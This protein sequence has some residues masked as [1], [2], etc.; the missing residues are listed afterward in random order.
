[1][2]TEKKPFL[3][4]EQ[5]E[6]MSGDA[7]AAQAVSSYEF[8]KTVG[9][10]RGLSSGRNIYERELSRREARYREVMQAACDAI[11][12]ATD[13][14][15]TYEDAEWKDGER[16]LILLKSMGIEPTNTK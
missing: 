16:V 10:A 9:M 8:G 3:S 15:R 11:H 7:L 2:T 6:R 5:I 13:Y 12:R 1:M 14:A 4:D